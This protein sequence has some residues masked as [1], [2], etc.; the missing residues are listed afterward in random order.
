MPLPIPFP[1]RPPIP[2]THPLALLPKPLPLRQAL[3][4]HQVRLLRYLDLP[5]LPP[6][7]YRPHQRDASSRRLLQ[8][9][10]NELGQQQPGVHTRI[11]AVAAA[12]AGEA[13]HGGQL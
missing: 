13:A 1:Y 3:P 9:G 8:Q 10:E 7:Y 6:F 12:G 11:S 4:R 5:L 2:T